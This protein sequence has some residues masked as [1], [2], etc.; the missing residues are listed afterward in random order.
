MT[1]FDK[2][3][4]KLSPF[5]S[6]NVKVTTGAHLPVRHRLAPFFPYREAARRETGRKLCDEAKSPFDIGISR[7]PGV[8]EKR[9]GH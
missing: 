1:E 8:H 2:I 4:A 3:A 6:R 7:S 9:P 5:C